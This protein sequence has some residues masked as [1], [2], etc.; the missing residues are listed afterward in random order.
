MIHETSLMFSASCRNFSSLTRRTSV[1]S[2]NS[3]IFCSSLLT[4]ASLDNLATVNS[5]C[6][7]MRPALLTV[8]VMSFE[9]IIVDV[10][11]LPVNR[12]GGRWLHGL[13]APFQFQ[14][15]PIS[16][17]QDQNLLGLCRLSGSQRL[18]RRKLRLHKL[19]KTAN[20]WI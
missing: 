5:C 16:I 7:G 14:P 12:G 11:L 15:S 20:S 8:F 19:H 10:P 6:G 2:D 9:L 17:V 1:W 18:T 4:G 13:T 3:W